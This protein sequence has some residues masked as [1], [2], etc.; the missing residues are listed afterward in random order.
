MVVHLAANV[1]CSIFTQE[2]RKRKL[3][4]AYYLKF[5]ALSNHRDQVKTVSSKCI[6][7]SVFCHHFKEKNSGFN[8]AFMI[9]HTITLSLH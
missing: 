5:I 3:D 4:K 2:D 6:I 9:K 1:L 7:Y 8:Q